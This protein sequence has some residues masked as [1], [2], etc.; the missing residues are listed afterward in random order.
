MPQPQSPGPRQ[1]LPTPF[2]CHSSP[3][4]PL[5]PVGEEIHVRACHRHPRRT[6]GPRPRGP[7]GREPRNPLFDSLL[8]PG[9]TVGPGLRAKLPP[10]TMPDGLD[11]AKQKAVITALI[12]DDHSYED[13]TRKSVVTRSC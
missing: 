4:K 10:P 1:R 11:A 2:V 12:R 3:R 5:D 9:L 6:V 7:G 13:F 8:D